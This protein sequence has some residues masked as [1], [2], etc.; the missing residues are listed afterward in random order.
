MNDSPGTLNIPGRVGALDPTWGAWGELLLSTPLVSGSGDA[1][2]REKLCK[3]LLQTLTSPV[4]LVGYV[5]VLDQTPHLVGGNSD[6]DPGA[7]HS[8]FPCLS[9]AVV[10]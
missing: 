5:E 2:N 6:W 8:F 7:N 4:S 1:E 9:V 10:L 3:S